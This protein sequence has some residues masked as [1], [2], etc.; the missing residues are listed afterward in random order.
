MGCYMKKKGDWLH[1]VFPGEAGKP[2]SAN[3]LFDL[4]DALAAKR[5]FLFE[6]QYLAREKFEGYRFGI[7]FDRNEVGIYDYGA[8]MLIGKYIQSLSPSEFYYNEAENK[9]SFKVK[10]SL[11]GKLLPEKGNFK[12]LVD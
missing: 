6:E 5:S 1:F 9:V 2:V 4:N 12:L 11:F 3:L 8:N 10:K 7:R